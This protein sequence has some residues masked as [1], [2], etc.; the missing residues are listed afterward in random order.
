L[1]SFDNPINPL[2][3][4][5]EPVPEPTPGV[6]ND[7]TTTPPKSRAKVVIFGA[8]CVML[9]LAAMG[10]ATGRLTVP[11]LGLKKHSALHSESAPPAM[12]VHAPPPALPAPA[13]APVVDPRET[14][15]DA[16]KEWELADGRTLGAALETLSPPVGNLSPWMAEPSPTAENRVSVNYFAQPSSPGAPTVAYQFEVDLAEKT[17]VGRNPAA[18]A[19]LAGKAVRP[20]SPPKPKPVKIKPKAKPKAAAPKKEDNLDS[21]LGNETP[22]AP[23][24]EATLAGPAATPKTAASPDAAAPSAGAPDELGAAPG[25]TDASPAADEAPAP[26]K[27]TTAKRAAKASKAAAPAA[28]PATDKASDESLLD[29]ILKE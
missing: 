1:P 17:L 16:A 27:S 6:V 15:I 8:L 19:V 12:P 29:D 18:K 7:L 21:L 2:S 11:G 26:V 10:I 23:K 5:P 22:A 3:L 9:A 13:P 14:A 28:A 24:A 25:T 20:P 4:A